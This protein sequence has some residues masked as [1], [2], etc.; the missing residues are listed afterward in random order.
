MDNISYLLTCFN[1]EL[2]EVVQESCKCLR[3][4]PEHT[5]AGIYDT[6]NLHRL[7]LE[8]ADVLAV[9][10]LLRSSGIDVGLE[11]PIVMPPHMKK[12]FAEKKART[13]ALMEVS[14]ILGTLK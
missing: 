11:E 3:F 8:T 14:K 13:L 10:D 12:R 5:P 4:G 1:E 7:Q 9:A 2:A 6:S